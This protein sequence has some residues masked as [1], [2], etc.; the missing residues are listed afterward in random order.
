[1]ERLAVEDEPQLRCVLAALVAFSNRERVASG[2]S[3]GVALDS[4][5]T[6]SSPG[7]VDAR[8]PKNSIICRLC[9][10]ALRQN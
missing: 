4:W 1:L 3:S 9:S 2:N 7:V 6:F 8:T 5:A 10:P